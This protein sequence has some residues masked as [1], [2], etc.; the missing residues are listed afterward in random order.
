MISFSL[1]WIYSHQFWGAHGKL[2]EDQPSDYLELV[3]ATPLQSSCVFFIN[4][5]DDTV[6]V[7][8]VLLSKDLFL[9]S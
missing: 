4:A 2:E 6:G 7:L 5:K 1:W 3:K 8:K 9:E